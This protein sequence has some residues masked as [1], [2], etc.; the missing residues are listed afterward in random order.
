TEGR[1]ERRHVCFVRTKR[2]N[3]RAQFFVV[4]AG[5][6]STMA[7][8]G[9]LS[10]KW[11]NHKTTFFHV[12]STIRSKEAY[13]DATIACDGRFYP[14]H[15][16]VMSTCSDYFEEMF[17]RTNCKHPVIVLKDIRHEDLEALL[18]YMYVGEVNVLQN[19]LAGLI[20]AAE[21]LMI[22]GL[23]VPDEAPSKDSPKENKRGA[24]K[25]ESPQAKRRRRDDSDSGRYDSGSSNSVRTSSQNH[26][27]RES[28]SSSSR[29]H[30]EQQSSR[31]SSSASGQSSSFRRP[32]SSPHHTSDSLPDDPG[33]SQNSTQDE[34]FQTNP[35]KSRSQDM[36][37]SQS[38]KSVPE[39]VLD[40]PPGVK[41]E[42]QEIQ[43]VEE[44]QEVEDTKNILESSFSYDHM[45]EGDSMS[46][47]GDGGSQGAQ[48]FDAQM[49][50]GAPQSMEELVAQAMP[51]GSGM[52]GN[53]LWESEGSLQ[54]F[55]PEFSD[56]QRGPQMGDG[57]SS[58]AVS[59]ASALAALRVCSICG[60]MGFR[61]T[62]D[63]Q[64]HMLSHTTV[65][66]FKCPHCLYRASLKY[67]LDAH[68]RLKHNN[69][70]ALGNVEENWRFS[71]SNTRD[72]TSAGYQ[73]GNVNSVMSNP[74]TAASQSWFRKKI[75]GRA[76]E[77]EMDNMQM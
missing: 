50:S 12:L 25:E 29:E 56:A 70:L 44:V 14:V 52:Q 74:G 18:N 19:E 75:D 32:A 3:G 39:V 6:L 10:L 51:G 45:S 33:P 21:C 9:L 46:N 7:S 54:G 58:T 13:C 69:Q 11:N 17:E 62:Y 28:S 68:V 35:E 47:I 71:S 16:L 24:T 55:P 5:I 72:I 36:P 37:S 42:P 53:S 67:N 76:E 8:G 23:A 65:R 34:N 66:P 2:G 15:K 27:H 30:R 26:S 20:K 60:K 41:E 40:E 1:G 73:Q 59:G 4:Y 49:M 38:Q 77:N 57:G 31:H 61:R 64:R 22:K 43:E 48:S 63:F